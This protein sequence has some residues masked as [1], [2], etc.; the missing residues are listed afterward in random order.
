MT[1][2]K[3]LFMVGFPRSGTTLAQSVV[4]ND[5]DVY[6]MPETHIF[7]KGMRL[8]KF[9]NFISNIW[10]SIYIYIW[11]KGNYRETK[12]IYSLSTEK[13]IKQFFMFFEKKAINEGKHIILEKTPG[14]LNRIDYISKVFPQARFIHVIRSYQ[15]A[16]PSIIKVSQKWSGNSSENFNV[17]RWL[18]EVYL[19]IS[20]CTE[21]DSHILVKYEDIVSNRSRVITSIN[22][23]LKLN[24]V[25]VGDDVLV[26][27]AK[28][29]VNSKETWKRNNL[30]GQRT[31]SKVDVNKFIF[32]RALPS[33]FEYLS[34]LTEPPSDEI[35][36]N[37]KL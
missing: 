12:F 21:R 22:Y 13:L 18:G 6:S 11:I 23:T 15:G 20:L 7:T 28:T 3:Y 27:K 8:G 5:N 36:E 26:S 37:E 14:H 32:S 17:R 30:K 29:I 34:S 9:P 2:L 25:D 1:E 35:L 19:S 16:I 33:Y 31:P 24:I 4:M 10:T